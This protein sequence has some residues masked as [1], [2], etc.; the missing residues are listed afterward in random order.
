MKG[1][2]FGIWELG[3]KYKMERAFECILAARMH[4]RDRREI[5]MN[6][7]ESYLCIIE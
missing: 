5:G 6:N 7:D 4:V 2:G 3:I 1:L